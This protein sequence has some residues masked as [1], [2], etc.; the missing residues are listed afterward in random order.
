MLLSKVAH[1][2]DLPKSHRSSKNCCRSQM[3]LSLPNTLPREMSV[4]ITSKYIVG[5]N[6][7]QAFSG[8][9]PSKLVFTIQSHS[10]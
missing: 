5:A 9:G 6:N 10:N 7:E 3:N 4:I 8:K 1:G 2:K